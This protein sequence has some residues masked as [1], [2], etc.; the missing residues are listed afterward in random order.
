MNIYVH[1]DG[2]N[3][4]PYSVSQLREFLAAR[5]FE[6]NDLACYDGATWI[7]LSEVPGIQRTPDPVLEQ[8][9]QNTQ[10]SKLSPTANINTGADL[11]EV[12]P[13][14][15]SKK[16]IFIL[17]GAVVASICM[18]G[19]LA[20]FLTAS[21]DVPIAS[22]VDSGNG[23]VDNSLVAKAPSNSDQS[24]A[25]LALPKNDRLPNTTEAIAKLTPKVV[26]PE[27]HL[28][29]L[30]MYCMDCHNA[31]SQKGEVNLESLSFT[32]QNIE[33]AENWQKVLH[34]LNSKEMP[35]E[36]KTQPD[37][38][39]KADFLD[40]LSQTMVT[41]RKVLSDSGG[42]ITMRR[43]NK[44]DYQNTIKS[45]LGV[46]LD[47]EILPEDGSSGE[48]DTVGSSLFMSSD[49]FEQYLK[50]GR[51]AID[52]FFERREA[53]SAKPFVYRVEPEETLNVAQRERVKRND[54]YLKR[55][56]ALDTEVEKAL[57]LPENKGFKAKLGVRGGREQFYRQLDQHKSKLKGAPNPKDFGFG[58]FFSAAKFYPKSAPYDKHYVG[59]PHSDTG[60]W[61]QLTM[62][63]S[64]IVIAPKKKMP[65]GT[66]SLRIQAGVSDQVSEFRHF[67]EFGYASE[68]NLGRGQL[69]GFPLKAL[70]V[71]GSPAKPEVI[72]TQ[73]LVGK[74]TRR[75]FAIRE[76]QPGWGP[77]RK[78]YFYPA[79]NR[80]GYGHEPSIWVDWVEIKGPLPQKSTSPL[81]EILSLHPADSKK[82]DQLRAR[83]ILRQ[84]AVKAFREKE[85]SSKFIDSL[86]AVFENR[87]A[88]DKEFDIAIRTPLSM[89]LASPRFLFIREPGQEGS[90]RALDDL[91]LAVRLSYFLWSSPPDTQLL[92][93]AKNK[94]LSDPEIL[95]GQVDRLI[96]DHRAHNFVSGLA[97]Q[98]LDMKRLDFFQFNAKDHREFDESTR[99]AVRE[100]VYQ[101]MLYLLR[102]RNE[103]ELGHLLDTDFAVINGLLGA[104][105]GIK[106]VKGDQFRK[107]SLPA[108]SPRGG[109]LGMAAI[110][111]MGSDGMESSP[112]ERGAWVLR[113]LVHNP[114]PP[115][116]A[117]VPQI[118]RLDGKP[119][120]KRQK[121]A[122]HMEEAQCASCHRKMDPIGFGM[123]NFTASGKWRE[124][125]GSG[126]RTHKINPSGKFHN[127]P[128]FEDFFELRE[129]IASNH[130]DDFA[131]GFTE[132]LIE[133]GLGRP[134]GFTDE[135]LAQS[136]LS[137]AKAK[138]Y[139][140]SEFIHT[141]VQTKEFQS[142]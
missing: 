129:L 42:K 133:Y 63:S 139:A 138:N 9:T 44:R 140:L 85:P 67:L 7:K 43:L 101:T 34:V 66:Y 62:G 19:L 15:K 99:T 107:V 78:F 16:K 75:E 98:W 109:L 125:E 137:S 74:D 39:L 108:G 50:L 80:N 51:Y 55:Y 49:K 8:T 131:R 130:Q 10:T 142:K 124:K 2:N 136:V 111:A 81:N 128:A 68:R 118:S 38:G 89:I 41:A 105:Y 64:K 83:Y 141:L 94:R 77:L 71:T 1:K 96:Q 23:L 72:E 35:P 46:E 48:F 25:S 21:N 37:E 92:E 47:K 36:D 22:I 121:L 116:P 79:M 90:P 113:H 97:H 103:G 69:E 114:P 119:L 84:F 13:T 30:D 17:S 54:E 127:G 135:D 14:Q 45:L 104:H 56:E 110:H 59:L 32:I 53:R 65:V 95:R 27:K 88:I 82:S 52:E 33:Q 40:D 12:K 126:K 117:N 28:D 4:G 123:E 70:H 122:A 86:V 106:D 76:R 3:Y 134:F 26:F 132:A 20:Y 24:A 73:L 61:L 93:L 102:S 6:G 115:A 11:H 58:N 87:L 57:A 60:T 5:N 120:T 100:E 112:V 31:D 29:F 91:E 18:I